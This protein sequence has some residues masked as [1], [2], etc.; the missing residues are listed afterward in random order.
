[1][2]NSKLHTSPKKRI[3]IA[4]DSE[5]NQEMLT[6][7]LGTEY[8][9]IYA[10]NGE[11]TLALLS[12]NLRIDMI[13]LDM[14]MPKVSGMQVLK[15]MREKNWLKEIP[16]VII[17]AEND[18]NFIQNAYYLG[19]ADYIVRPFNTFLVQNR[20]KNTLMMYTQK[21]Q[22]VRMVESQVFRREKINNMLIT[23][24][25]HIMEIGNNE[26]G[27]HTLNVQLITNMLLKRL[28]KITDRYNLSEDDISIISSS[29]ALHDIGKIM[30]PQK[31]LNKPGK[32]TDEEWQIMKDHTII[33]DEFLR[34]I[35]IDQ[36]EKLMIAAHEICRHHHERFDGSGYP[37]GLKG[38]E[39]PISAQAVSIADAYDALTSERCY[40]KAYSHENA[41]DMIL[42][43]ECGAFN[44][45]LLK[46]FKDISDELVTILKKESNRYDLTGNTYLLANEVLE[47]ENI[48]I[49]ER[50]EN[51]AENERIK[52][53]FYAERC[54]GIQFEYDAI[55]R[56]IS[57]MRYRNKKGTIVQLQRDATHILNEQDSDTFDKKAKATTPDNSDFTMTVLI[58]INGNLRWHKL[59]A[60][61][62]WTSNHHSFVAIIGQFIDIHD[63]VIRKS[64]EFTLK[65]K[66]INGDSILAMSNVFDIVRVVDPTSCETMNLNQDGS[67]TKTGQKCFNI[68]NRTE[69]CQNCSSATAL[70]N[71]N[72]TSKLETKDGLLYSVLSRHIQCDNK[73][74][75]LE[76]A[77]CIDESFE[78]TKNEIGFLPDSLTLKNYYRDTLT[79]TYSRAYL[80]SFMPNL[81]NSKGV[82]IADI[83]EFKSINDTFGHIAG[84]AALKHISKVIKSCIR[85]EDILI[86]YGGD[87]FLLIFDNISEDDF[88]NKL[89]SIKQAV[90]NSQIKNYP[91][92]KHDISIGG[93][94]GIYPFE[95][96]VDAADKA[97][98]KDKF[99]N[100]NWND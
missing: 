47:T 34:S 71:K 10:A 53:E 29:A 64:A 20:V 98:Y 44:P 9:Y 30:I 78:K 40:K 43:G 22:L 57:Y 77:F 95:K 5:L 17:S 70:N 39:I 15:V 35:P 32:L 13:L 28:V 25:S 52:K 92:I 26:S 4:D 67:L 50:Y 89:K 48:S 60:R 82:A 99:K 96:A 73:D 19:V 12:D 11:Q 86:R 54:T 74:Y 90:H 62:I 18:D 3:L 100:K 75:V 21:K 58:N 14:N 42:N 23:I 51:L 2:L 84:D 87:E 33:G 63:D 76:V 6:E 83:D 27:Q 45:L 94:Y 37:D 85:K 69:A 65:D 61:T 36:N 8:E 79:K 31:I 16:V 66:T 68:W 49:D 93:A 55:T 91:D 97:M 56:N 81:E 24:F 72:W 41:R 7:I 80:E 88:F 46:C 1:M 38:D 59:Y